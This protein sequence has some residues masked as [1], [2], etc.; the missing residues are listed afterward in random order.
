MNK[1]E[2]L[3]LNESIVKAV[4]ELGFESPT[5]IQEQAIPELL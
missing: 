4:T 3:G 5:P 1:F 2:A